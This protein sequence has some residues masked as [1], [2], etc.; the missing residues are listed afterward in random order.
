MFHG[1]LKRA[2]WNSTSSALPLFFPLPAKRRYVS[3]DS[4]HRFQPACLI[5]QSHD[6]RKQMVF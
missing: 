4:R 6:F 5:M 3:P 2:Y 1:Q